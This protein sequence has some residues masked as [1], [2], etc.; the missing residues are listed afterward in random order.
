MSIDKIFVNILN[1][2]LVTLLIVSFVFFTSCRKSKDRVE[3]VPEEFKAWVCFQKGSYWI[4]MSDKEQLVDS[5]V[6]YM[7]PIIH[8]H[9]MEGSNHE[10][11]SIEKIYLRLSSGVLR[12]FSISPSE[13]IT[14]FFNFASS[15]CLLS[16]ISL[17]S[18][19]SLEGDF[20]LD[21]IYPSYIINDNEF[22]NVVETRFIPYAGSDTNHLSVTFFYAKNIGLIRYTLRS[23]DT[24]TWSLVRWNV[25]Q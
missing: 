4:Y 21:T 16:D 8:Y 22:T 10:K 24:V 9:T 1:N 19:H 3:L 14:D 11:I 15:T 17:S 2:I 23:S 25:N 7:D 13:C 12:G 18:Q 20:F 6:L 5:T